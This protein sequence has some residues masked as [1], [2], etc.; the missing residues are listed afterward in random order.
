MGLL[1]IPALP[2][3]V[4]K[5]LPR[6]CSCACMGI[7]PL[8]Q[9]EQISTYYKYVILDP[10]WSPAAPLAI[11][12][13]FSSILSPK[14]VDFCLTLKRLFLIPSPETNK[15]CFYFSQKQYL[16]LEERICCPFLASIFLHRR[17]GY[18]KTDLYLSPLNSQL[19]PAH[20][21]KPLR[22][23]VFSLLFF[24]NL[25]HENPTEVHAK[26]LLSEYKLSG[27][28]FIPR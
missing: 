23:M 6:I 21:K 10:R 2:T 19:P 9:K 27:V 11:V 14:A 17:E 20:L 1:S 7:F 18:R 3:H 15:L 24:S 28:P 16:Y 8:S 4:S 5:T 22:G 25:S 12:Y 13:F 26:M